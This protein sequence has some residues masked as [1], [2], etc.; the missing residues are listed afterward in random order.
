MPYGETRVFRQDAKRRWQERASALMRVT[1]EALGN[2][3]RY[4]CGSGSSVALELPA[5]STVRHALCAVGVPAGVLWNASIKG[6]LVY[7]DTALEERDRVLVF[8]P[9]GGGDGGQ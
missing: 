7:A 9:I 1:I 8:A 3:R 5:G 2:L 4:L 6:R